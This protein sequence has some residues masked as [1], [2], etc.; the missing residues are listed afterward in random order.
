MNTRR[1]ASRRLEEERV[2]KEVPPQV[3]QVPQGSQGVQG[4]RDSQVPTQ[5]DPIPYVEGG[6]EVS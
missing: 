2:N 3:E 5:G 1:M 4:A 6:I